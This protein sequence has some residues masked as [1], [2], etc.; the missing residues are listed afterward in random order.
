MFAHLEFD[1]DTDR[2][3]LILADLTPD[4]KD[5]LNCSNARST[6]EAMQRSHGAALCRLEPDSRL[7]AN[8]TMQSSALDETLVRALKNGRFC[9]KPLNKDHTQ[10]KQQVSLLAFLTP[11]VGSTQ[12]QSQ[13][14][15]SQEIL[16]LE[17]TD[18]DKTRP[19]PSGTLYLGGQ[20]SKGQ[21]CQR[22]HC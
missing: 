5:I 19:K 20:L 17:V 7:D 18:L 15:A 13:L 14:S 3:V 1:E 10:A 12:Y 16:T 21:Q 6:M 4:F 9:N 22:C 2:D 8:V 11:D